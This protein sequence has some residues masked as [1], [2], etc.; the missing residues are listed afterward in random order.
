M[1]L[2]DGFLLRKILDDW[3]VV[4]TGENTAKLN[5]MLALSESSALLWEALEAGSDVDALVALLCE[6]YRVDQETA[7]RDTEK[8]LQTLEQAGI[9]T[10]D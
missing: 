10:W 3:I 8:Y 2:A 6:T 5:G 7:R 4:P 1:K 9:L